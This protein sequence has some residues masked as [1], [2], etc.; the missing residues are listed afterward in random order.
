ME[1][2]FDKIIEKKRE[3][4]ISDALQAKCE[5][6][7]LWI[8]ENAGTMYYYPENG[9]QPTITKQNKDILLW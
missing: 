4:L 8:C 6:I 3:Y 9:K 1:D 5:P 2:N 7:Y